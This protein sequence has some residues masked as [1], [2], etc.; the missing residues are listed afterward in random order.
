MT[1]TTNNNGD[2]GWHILKQT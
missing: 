2:N 1:E